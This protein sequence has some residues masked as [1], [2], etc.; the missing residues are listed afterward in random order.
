MRAHSKYGDK[1]TNHL[2]MEEDE[3][4]NM[5]LDGQNTFLSNQELCPEE[6]EI[7]ETDSDIKGQ[8]K[9]SK[10]VLKKMRKILKSVEPILFDLKDGTLKRTAPSRFNRT[11]M[12]SLTL[13][14]LREDMD[15]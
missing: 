9:E 5:S 10:Q 13:N 14:G 1:L 12:D 8:L 7:E 2:E 11:K 6:Q 4:R 15:D 3:L